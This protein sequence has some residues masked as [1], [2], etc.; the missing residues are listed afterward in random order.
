MTALAARGPL[1]QRDMAAKT[2]P[3]F[4]G[5]GAQSLQ[6]KQPEPP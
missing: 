2:H 3:L 4:K 6:Q 5:P 1:E